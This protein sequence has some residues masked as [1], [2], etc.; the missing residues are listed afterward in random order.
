MYG[1]KEK[2]KAPS[3]PSRHWVGAFLVEV[4]LSVAKAVAVPGDLRGHLPC[5]WDAYAGLF[6]PTPALFLGP[7][8]VLLF[9]SM[10]N[11]P[12]GFVSLRCTQKG[13]C[14]VVGGDLVCLGRECRAVAPGCLGSDCG[15]DSH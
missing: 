15:S 12:V 3:F 9:K 14:H 4:A 13:A 6:F 8:L 5:C 11:V 10:T 2:R 1:L 7:G